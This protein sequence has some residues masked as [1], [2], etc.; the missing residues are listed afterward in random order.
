M[1]QYSEFLELVCKEFINTQ[2]SDIS[3]GKIKEFIKNYELDTYS[4]KEIKGIINELKKS[5]YECEEKES[6][7]TALSQDEVF[8]L[9]KDDLKQVLFHNNDRPL[10]TAQIKHFIEVYD[11][12]SKY[13][14]LP[15]DVRRRMGE[16]LK[17]QYPDFHNDNDSSYKSHQ[18]STVVSG[19]W[20]VRNGQSEYVKSHIRKYK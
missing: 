3:N 4:V 19:Y 7:K 13:G 17:R 11:L 15:C 10:N 18:L 5:K 2:N 20:R 9:Y 6:E 8:L 12:N 16:L 14:V 1:Y